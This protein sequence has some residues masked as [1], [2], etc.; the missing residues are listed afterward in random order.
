[1]RFNTGVAEGCPFSCAMLCLTNECLARFI[2]SRIPR[3]VQGRVELH[4]F[5]DN[6]QLKGDTVNATAEFLKALKQFTDLYK[7]HMSNSNCWF[8][9]STPAARKALQAISLNNRAGEIQ[10]KTSERDLGVG[11]FYSKKQKP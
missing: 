7:L 6:W 8:W 3:Q 9:A 5:A 4:L 2:E 10:V 1:M 11:V